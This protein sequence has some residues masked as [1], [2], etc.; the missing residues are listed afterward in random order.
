M[1]AKIKDMTTGRPLP[2]IISFALPLMVGNIFQQLYTVVDT[3]V[4]G[5]AL[6]VDALAALGA[7]DWL[8]WMLLGMI[9]G[10][11]Q[12]FGILMAR[13][14]GAKQYESLRKVVGSSTSLSIIFALLFLILGQA[15]AKP[16]LVLLNTPVQIMD[17]SLLYLRIMFLG[18][19]IVM[20][21]NLLATILRSLG[22]GQTPLYA[23][24]VAALTNIAL[25][26]LFVLV[27][28]LGIAGAAVATLIAQGISSIYCLQK[29]RKINFMTLK[30][31]HFA[32]EPALAGQLLSLGSPMAAQNAIIAVG[33]MIIQGVVNGYGV[34]FIGGFTATNKLYG[35]LE[36]AATSYGYAMITYVGQNLGAARIERIKT[37][38]G[39]AI[40][41][42]LAT[43]ALIAAVML[44]FGQYIIGAFISGTP[45]EAAA[46]T[47]VGVTYLSVMSIC[48]PI[49][50][51]LH[52]TRSAV[53]GMG[54]TVLPM[55]SGIAEFI[56]RTGGVLILPALM[57]ENGIFIA[58]VLAWLGADLILVPSYFVMVKRILR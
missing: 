8:Y 29:I 33:G 40:A 57:G 20:I 38:M 18:I 54:N 17:G 22:D 58:E 51:I 19:P 28:H 1:S 48:L 4:V 34:A 24:I 3:M 47:K 5:K 16:I 49:L 44:G 12:G 31:K 43:S 10:V 55:V 37:G 7:T 39:W 45:E 42:A 11:T 36:I 13:E 53:Q 23:M 46:A 21:Y 56:M 2:L 50:Y 14:F 27:L 6:G 25:D 41:V 15:V 30:K 32:L 52:V 9:Q 35:V 26:I